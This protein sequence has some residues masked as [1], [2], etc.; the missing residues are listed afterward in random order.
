MIIIIPSSFLGITSKASQ[1]KFHQIRITK[2]ILIYVQI[3]LPKREKT[4]KWETN[5]RFTKRGKKR[6][7]DRGRF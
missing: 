4:K 6:I 1:T 3:P 7:T 5:F 2:S